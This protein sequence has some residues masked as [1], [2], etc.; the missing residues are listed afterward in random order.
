MLDKNY[1]VCMLKQDISVCVDNTS[2]QSDLCPEIN[3]ISVK[4]YVATTCPFPLGWRPLVPWGT[5]PSGAEREMLLWSAE[6]EEE[7]LLV[8]PSLLGPMAARI[9]FVSYSLQQVRMFNAVNVKDKCKEFL[10]EKSLTR[11]E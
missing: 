11:P 5:D 2:I 1:R 7:A 4:Q 8:Q 10:T 6:K 9:W 3:E